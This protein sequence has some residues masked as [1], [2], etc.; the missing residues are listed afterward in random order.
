MAPGPRR[1]VTA[2]LSAE[3]LELGALP[4]DSTEG[5]AYV[6]LLRCLGEVRQSRV[7]LLDGAEHRDRIALQG[8]FMF[9]TCFD[10]SLSA[11]CLRRLL[12]TELLCLDLLRVPLRDDEARRRPDLG[13]RRVAAYQLCPWPW[14]GSGKLCSQTEESYT[15]HVQ[16]R[17]TGPWLRIHLSAKVAPVA[18]P[19]WPSDCQGGERRTPRSGEGE[20]EEKAEAA[21][22][23]AEALRLNMVGA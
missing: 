9:Q 22:F 21:F 12:A 16:S 15:T 11:Q 23:A 7:F 10:P 5:F 2:L 13:A 6:F 14:V 20:P 19:P 4:L 3:L 17:R 1:A 8:C 18:S